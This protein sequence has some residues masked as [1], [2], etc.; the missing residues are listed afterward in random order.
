MVTSGKKMEQKLEHLTSSELRALIAELRPLEVCDLVER[1]H[2]VLAG[3][4]MLE[5]LSERLRQAK[6]EARAA[7]RQLCSWRLS[8]PLRTRL[9]YWGWMPSRFLAE[10]ESGKSRLETEVLQ[11]TQRV[12]L[13]AE[14]AKKIEREVEVQIQLEQASVRE[15]IAELEYLWQTRV[16]QEQMA[17]KQTQ[18]PDSNL[19]PFMT[20]KLM[21]EMKAQ[22]LRL[23]E[24]GHTSAGSSHNIGTVTEPKSYGR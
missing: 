9:H 10:R 13:T 18:E 21:R 1:E 19:S 7:H 17:R 4:Q 5:S 14:H 20:R 11:L 12:Y 22:D 3:R 8:H 23:A 6:T 24:P 16:A 2:Q 15:R